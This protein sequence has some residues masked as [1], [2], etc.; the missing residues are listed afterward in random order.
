MPAGLLATVTEAL[1]GVE[2][3]VDAAL[4]GSRDLLV[5]ALLYDRCV[6]SRR[7][8]Q[9]LADDLLAANRQWLPHFA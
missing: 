7:V 6:T 5:Q 9:A 2:I 8:A 1:Y 3:T 4:Q